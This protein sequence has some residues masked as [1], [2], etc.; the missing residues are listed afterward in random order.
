MRPLY[1]VSNIKRPN[2]NYI[3][4]GIFGWDF[5]N[6]LL[7]Y[8]IFS[9]H[10]IYIALS[11]SFYLIGFFSIYEIGY[12]ENDTY[13][14]KHEVSPRVHLNCKENLYQFNKNLAWVYGIFLLSVGAAIQTWAVGEFDSVITYSV[15]MTFIRNFA[16]AIAFVLVTRLTF[17]IFNSLRPRRRIIP[18]LGLQIERT[19]GYALML[20]ISSIGVALCLSHSFARWFPYVLY[21]YGHRREAFPIHVGALVLFACCTGALVAI[22]KSSKNDVLSDN[23][24]WVVVA[25]LGLRAA[26]Q[27]LDLFRTE[28]MIDV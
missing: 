15:T 2:E 3:F 7:A 4:H 21:R 24:F 8:V 25:Y 10:P 6:G 12:F 23:Q 20:P 13:A 11:F 22:Q 5:L 14:V 18:M 9:S 16:A 28:S 1:Y 19:L 26:K 17:R 27:L